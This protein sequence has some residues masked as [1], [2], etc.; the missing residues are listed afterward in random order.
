MPNS[1]LAEV[2]ALVLNIAAE[3]NDLK[4]AAG[5][6]V[7]NAVAGWLA[8]LYLLEARDKLTSLDGTARFKVLPAFVQDLGH[9]APWRSCGGA[10]AA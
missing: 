10:V 5:G 6:H 2:K 3:A 8:P 9:A 4:S 7:T 1:N